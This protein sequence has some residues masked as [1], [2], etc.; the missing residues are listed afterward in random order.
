MHKWFHL[1]AYVTVT[2]NVDKTVKRGREVYNKLNID[3]Y[4]HMYI[5]ENQPNNDVLYGIMYIEHEY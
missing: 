2:E 3:M 4:V 5:K 1:P